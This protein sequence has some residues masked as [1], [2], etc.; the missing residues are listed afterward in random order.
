MKHLVLRLGA[1]VC[2]VTFG[3]PAACALAAGPTAIGVDSTGVVYAGYGTGGHIQEFSGTDGS[4][5]GSWGAP[6]DAPGLL[7]GVVAIDVAPGA[8]GDVWVLDTNRR[9][10]EFTRS[11][12][13]VRGFQ[14]SA[15]AA[16][17]TPSPA[18]RGGLDVTTTD[19][20]VAH[21]CSDQVYRYRV[22]DLGL[23][24]QGAPASGQ[25]G[26]GVSAQL[27]SS[28]PSQTNRTYVAYPGYDRVGKL[29]PWFSLD[30]SGGFDSPY[31]FHQIT[32]GPT[33]VFVDAFGVLFVSETGTDEIHLLD[34]NGSEFR[35]IGGT[36]TDPGKLNDP[37][38]FDVFEQYSDLAGNVFVADYG[39]NR[40][41][42]MN[43]Y[44]YTFWAA[45]AT[46]ATSGNGGGGGTT[47]A[48]A[49]TAPPAISGTP[50]V[51]QTL[52]CST[53]T[54]SG[55]PTGYAYQWKQDSLAIGSATT[56]SY[57]VQSG[58]Q[59]HALTC[60]VTAT[61][62]GGSASAT[63]SA[64]NVGVSQSAPVN[65]SAPAITGT[66]VQGGSLACSSGTW[67]GS[68][69][70][71]GYQW[72]R[73]GSAI[74][75]ATGTS[76]VVQAAD[77]GH[78][79][80][81]TVTATNGAGSA[82]ATSAG[83]TPT[84]ATVTGPVGVSINAAAV[85]TNSPGVTLTIHEP[86]GATSVTI[87]NDGGFGPSAQ[88]VAVRGDDTYAW[89]LQTSGSER[90]PKTVY[91]RFSGGGIDGD[92][93]FTDDIILDQTAPVVTATALRTATRSFRI[94]ATDNGGSGIAKLQTAVS[95]AG[96]R[97]PATR[98]YRVRTTLTRT[99]ARRVRYVRVVDRAGNVGRWKRVH[100]TKR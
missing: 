92:R 53:G 29:Q 46:D 6:G 18:T 86:A 58:D 78:T 90:L 85:F 20:F 100:L 37:S 93:T 39:N 77:V 88:T 95:I 74:G 62:T 82:A 55:S 59:G 87:A 97:A 17:V 2:A 66:A 24:N 27:Y 43:P 1:L 68:P 10:Q 57:V 33:D 49:N 63:S 65:Q 83:V 23:N 67:S 4:V 51:G 47:Q 14:L 76:Y 89:T 94:V 48:P 31:G 5:V 25:V 21:P 61:N 19:I 73:D 13:Y 72:N 54:W 35:W 52:T 70:G 71:Y 26:R 16:G 30:N 50:S 84:T 28:A 34:A 36:G 69:T 8:T 38:A 41:Q 11:G 7:G 99:A 56:S 45:A 80:T 75:G 79:L 40:I 91:V 12:Q 42:R 22:S 64:V 60:T 81:C 15:C 9:V 3:L 96:E 44:G 98:A 32:S